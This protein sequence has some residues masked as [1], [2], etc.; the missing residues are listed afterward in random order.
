MPYLIDGHNLIAKTPGLSLQ[1]FDDENQLIELLQDFCRTRRKPVEVYFDNAPVGQAAV[2]RFGQVTAH[3]VRQ[4]ST[5]DAAIH[6]RLVRLGKSAGN[7]TVVSSDRAVQ[8]AARL[9]HAQVLS[10][11]RGAPGACAGAELG[12]LYRFARAACR[13]FCR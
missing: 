4:G 8:T 2:R 9:A 7:W 11:N 1:A 13:C 5:A 12:K 6:R 3:F 10:S